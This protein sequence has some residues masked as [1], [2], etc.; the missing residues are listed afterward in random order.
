[1][2]RYRHVSRAKPRLRPL[3]ARGTAEWVGGRVSLPAYITEPE[4]YRPDAIVWVELPGELVIAF[5]V[6]DPKSDAPSFADSLREAM[7]AP[8]AGPPR[9]PPRVRVAS[10]ALAIE[11]RTALAAAMTP[12]AIPEVVVASTP[13]IDDVARAFAEWSGPSEE[14]ESY[15]EGGRVSAT[16]VEALF[17]AA[18][19]LYH[20]APWKVVG[21]DQLIRL[22]VPELGIRGA[23]VS[24]IGALEENLGVLVFPSRAGYEAH[25]AVAE[26]Y[27]DE[28]HERRAPERLDIG[29]S[30]LS[31]TFDRA[32]D[33]PASLRREAQRH[34]WHVAAPHAY[35][36]V[37]HIDRDGLVRPHGEKEVGLLTELALALVSVALKHE[38]L[39]E[40][41]NHEPFSESYSGDTGPTVRLTAPYEAFELFET[42]EAGHE[43]GDD[44]AP[45]RP[46]GPPGPSARDEAPWREPLPAVRRIGRNELCPCGSGKKYKRCH[47]G[48]DL[49]G[50]PTSPTAA[51]PETAG[52]HALDR[53]LAEAM[54]SYLEE[55]SGADDLRLAK[56]VS[57]PLT[58]AQL[59][60]PWRLYHGKVAGRSPAERFA[61]DRGDRLTSDER[62]WI[63]AQSR[64]WLGIW[65]VESVDPGRSVDLH[66]LLTEERRHVIEASASN[67]AV[68][69]LAVLG[70][71]VDHR[72]LALLCGSHP[73]PLA[74]LEAAGVAR[75]FRGRLR[76]ARTSPIERLREERVGRDLIA[77]WEE[78]VAKL[79]ERSEILPRLRNSD[80][81]ELVFINERYDFDPRSRTEIEARLAGMENVM[82][83]ERGDADRDY[84]VHRAGATRG[85]LQDVMIARLHV[86]E[87]SLS[88]ETNSLR[89]ANE[90]RERVLAALGALVRRR[91]RR[92][93]DAQRMVERMW[94]RGPSEPRGAFEHAHDDLARSSEA[95]RALREMKDRHYAEWPDQPLPALDGK[96]ARQA[97][98]SKTGRE[99]VDALIKDIEYR[100]AMLP[101]TERFDVSSL[102]RRLG[103]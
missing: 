85:G 23:A 48:E 68:P 94:E 71:V 98:R 10:E 27:A 24:V 42:E 49:A 81:D 25:L 34:G 16:A 20:A 13:E 11:A 18:G 31:L 44:S 17:R 33:L 89:R 99:R 56:V 67:A 53:R 39:F 36:R 73:Q 30:L 43:G 50:A 76:R 86:D 62:E 28:I 79:R 95:Q 7:R 102:R 87:R 35:P 46:F 59:W 72:G 84:A 21:E 1:M 60:L 77:R 82:P 93:R 96:T 41:R 58:A 47:L 74:P 55:R 92:R 2:R 80:G 26:R 9:H 91:R 38:A 64:S 78:A 61:A 83:P 37:L 19:V 45:S 103:L 57:D 12:D 22:D 51:P 63:A 69:R 8:H 54:A 70:R 6:V 3:D 14:K 101:V 29:T 100:E 90:I 40:G 66:D 52:L 5:T 88:I 15:F 75:A 65:E 32:A 4:P 97:A